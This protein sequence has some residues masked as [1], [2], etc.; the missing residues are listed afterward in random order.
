MFVAD[1]DRVGADGAGWGV[2]MTVLTDERGTGEAGTRLVEATAQVGLL[3]TCCAA[4][5]HTEARADLA[6]RTA[7]LDWHVRRATEEKAAGADWFTAGSTLKVQWSELLQDCARLGVRT[8][9]ATHRDLWRF[10]YLESRAMSIY[11][12][13]NEIQRNIITDRVLGVPR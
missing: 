12:G 3:G 2:A 13:T 4:R 11:S 6:R 5:R 9:C 8:G 10:R 7:L 1:D